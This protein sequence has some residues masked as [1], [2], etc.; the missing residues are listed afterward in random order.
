MALGTSAGGGVS[1]ARVEDGNLV[2]LPA[3][4][5]A[6]GLAGDVVVLGGLGEG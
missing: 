6:S 1:L 5:L 3:S 4:V 2:P